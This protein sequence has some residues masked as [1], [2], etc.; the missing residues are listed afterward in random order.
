MPHPFSAEICCGSATLSSALKAAGFAVKPVDWDGNRHKTHVP[1]IRI[2]LTSPEGQQRLW[3]LLKAGRVVYIHLAPPCGTF[4]KARNIPISKEQLRRGA[5]NVRPLRDAE[6]PAGLPTSVIQMSATERIKVE[7]G[8]AIAEL[9]AVVL[10]FCVQSGIT[11]SV[12][13]PSG[14]FI[15]DLPSFKALASSTTRVDFDACMHGAA[16]DK[17]TTLLCSDDTFKSMEMKCDKS[18]KH[19][20]WGLNQTDGGKWEF[21]TAEECEYPEQMCKTMASLLQSKFQPE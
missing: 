19:K 9:C 3:R 20:P 12:E 2:D 1:F 16:R 21:R 5:P 18:H 10:A 14:S 17:K 11:A 13:N 15:W 8:N 6:H 7:K 4:S